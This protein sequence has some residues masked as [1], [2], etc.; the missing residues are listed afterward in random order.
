MLD[1]AQRAAATNT[2]DEAARAICDYLYKEVKYVRGVTS[3]HTP[4]THAWDVRSGVCQ[5]IAHLAIGAL[6]RRRRSPRA[7]SPATFTPSAT[8]R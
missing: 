5:D 2:P 3:V 1:F 8:P 6:A 7:T 4:A